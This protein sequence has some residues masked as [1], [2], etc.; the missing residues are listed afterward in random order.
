MSLKNIF[1]NY[2]AKKEIKKMFRK[3]EL[4]ERIEKLEESLKECKKDLKAQVELTKFL[5]EH[6]KNEVVVT[7]EPVFGAFTIGY[8]FVVKYVVDGEL[9]TIKKTTDSF[10]DLDVQEIKN[11]SDNITFIHLKE[12]RVDKYIQLDRKNKE[13]STIDTELAD[14]IQS[15]KK[16]NNTKKVRG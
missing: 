4:K 10:C 1:I 3:N 2:E 6:D 8:A 14:I 16:T 9:V 11:I 13:L 7:K 15:G 5:L 12:Y